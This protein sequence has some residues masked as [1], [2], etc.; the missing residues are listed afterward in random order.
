MHLMLQPFAVARQSL[1][2]RLIFLPT[3]RE[4]NHL[5]NKKLEIF[6]N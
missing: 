1:S 2:E 6:M 3:N 5:E 4:G